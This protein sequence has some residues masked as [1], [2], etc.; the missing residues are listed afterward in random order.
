MMRTR[1]GRLLANTSDATW[2]ITP[3]VA[4]ALSKASQ[5]DC[6]DM[7]RALVERG[8]ADVEQ[9][10][11]AE[12]GWPLMQAAD[13]GKH[14]MA[15]YLI[16]KGADL[17]R[18]AASAPA[19]AAK[20][21]EGN[22]QG[23]ST[24]TSLWMAAQNNHPRITRLILAAAAEQGVLEKLVDKTNRRGWTPCCI[25][26]QRGNVEVVGILHAA[27]ADLARAAPEYYQVEYGVEGRVANLLPGTEQEGAVVHYALDMAVRSRVLKR[28]LVCEQSPV[29]GVK[30]L[31]CTGCRMAYFAGAKYQKRG[32]RKHKL[33]CK[34]L[35]KGHRDMLEAMRGAGAGA[36]ANANAKVA[37][38]AGDTDDG[39]QD[40]ASASA[41]KKKKKTKKTK[42][43][44]DGATDA[45]TDTWTA[46]DH[47]LGELA[48]VFAAGAFDPDVHPRWEY[49]DGK[50]GKPHWVRYPPRI[51]VMLELMRHW[52]RDAGI[53][54]GDADTRTLYNRVHMAAFFQ[55]FQN[56]VPYSRRAQPRQED[57]LFRPGRPDCDHKVEHNDMQRQRE[58]AD[59]PPDFAATRRVTFATMQELDTYKHRI[60]SVRRNGSTRDTRANLEAGEEAQPNPSR[61]VGPG[62]Q[63]VADA[64]RFAAMPSSGDP[65]QPPKT[66]AEYDAARSRLG[67]MWCA[68]LRSCDDDDSVANGHSQIIHGD[69]MNG[70]IESLRQELNAG[71]HVDFRTHMTET[72]LMLAANYHR[73]ACV[74]LLL[75][76]GANVWLVDYR[77]KSALGYG[78]PG[79]SYY[80]EGDP[81][82]EETVRLLKEAMLVQQPPPAVTRP[83]KPDCRIC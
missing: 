9:T 12:G 63:N 13:C 19:S 15:E 2:G 31:S 56:E 67:R 55:K 77:G 42:G 25:A 7:C 8:G 59:Q 76:R 26:M 1:R 50:R 14:L 48:R 37:G 41:N 72:P 45:F 71:T 22:E 21:C 11:T 81:A 54:P 74:R 52:D 27:G 46:A 79:G 39:A 43:E 3:L 18:T 64:T 17:L 51:E 65:D 33:V 68:N 49:D 5:E 10:D 53:A 75:A 69:A 66:R 28:C 62:A 36:G 44:Q 78:G 23:R 4:V 29:D 38:A 57:F 24:T 47:D 20:P 70:N 30:L 61:P 83:E 60:R 82:S 73:V 40:E 32:W 6:V 58:N 35:G 34:G 16:S 80:K